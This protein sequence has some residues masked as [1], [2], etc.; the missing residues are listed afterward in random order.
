MKTFQFIVAGLFYL[1]SI[2]T[3]AGN[4][5]FER[6][7]VLGASVS[8][9]KRAP[10][11]GRLI[12]AKVGL[13]QS[14]FLRVARDGKKSTYFKRFIENDFDSFRPD[15]IV[16][17]DLFFHDYKTRITF[18][19][20]DRRWIEYV[21]SQLCKHGEQVFLGRA[22]GAY[23]ASKANKLLEKLERRY[24]NLH[25]V[26]VD[27]YFFSVHTPKGWVY[28]VN[29]QRFRVYRGDVMADPIHPNYFGTTLVANVVI[30]LA[31]KGIAGLEQSSLD[32]FEV[33]APYRSIVKLPYFSVG[34]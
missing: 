21:V 13:P 23:A 22:I 9:D 33:V 16:A 18:R 17:L 31:L 10:S 7:L 15:W 27:R 3:F 5:P 34:L 25:L 29:G 24:S 11:P 19:E 8:A 14:Q 32:Y 28:N 1:T 6:M 26:D 20:K 12:A 30:D 2:N 4:L